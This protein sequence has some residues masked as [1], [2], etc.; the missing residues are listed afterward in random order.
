MQAL[1]D[2]RFASAKTSGVY[3]C[4]RCTKMTREARRCEEPGYNNYKKPK[5]VDSYS[6][7]YT[8]CPGKATRHRWLLELYNQCVVATET[9]ILPREGGLE[10]QDQYFCEVFPVFVQRYRHR[11]YCRTWEQVGEFTPR[12]LEAIGKMIARMFGKK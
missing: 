1:V 9:G 8:F 10:H 3:R 6:L 7:K 5:P 12:V 2:L 11:M 4:S